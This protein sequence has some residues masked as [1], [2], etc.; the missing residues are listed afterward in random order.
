MSNLDGIHAEPHIVFLFVERGKLLDVADVFQAGF[1][2]LLNEI[3]RIRRSFG[4]EQDSTVVGSGPGCRRPVEIHPNVSFPDSESFY[5]Q[6][7]L[8]PPP[9]CRCRTEQI[10]C[11]VEADPDAPSKPSFIVRS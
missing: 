3:D 1:V 7:F 4:R 11:A 5:F 6:S 8:D 2:M 10:T 9:N